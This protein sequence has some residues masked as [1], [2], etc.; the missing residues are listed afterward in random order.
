MSS[1]EMGYVRVVHGV[2]V[3]RFSLEHVRIQ[4]LAEPILHLSSF[5]VLRS[6]LFHPPMQ[7]SQ[8]RNI[9]ERTTPIEM[10]GRDQIRTD[11][12]NNGW[13]DAVLIRRGGDNA[14]VMMA[15]D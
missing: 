9:H 8:P 5:Q 3:I 1:G 6:S 10:R 11:R 14:D 12:T 4:T 2:G 7:M 15:V 13:C